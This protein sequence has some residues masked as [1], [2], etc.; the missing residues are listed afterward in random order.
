MASR[1]AI[2]ALV[3][4]VLAFLTDRTTFHRPRA[5]QGHK[6]NP[7]MVDVRTNWM[8]AIY[9][10]VIG[11]VKPPIGLVRRRPVSSNGTGNWNKDEQELCSRSANGYPEKTKWSPLSGRPSCRV[12]GR[13]N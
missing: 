4:L 2:R 11:A 8:H 5:P 6:A 10:R 1:T 3:A 9:G 12:A 13:L 7:P